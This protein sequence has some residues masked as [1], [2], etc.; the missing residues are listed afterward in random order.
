MVLRLLLDSLKLH[1]GK[2]SVFIP[3]VGSREA[4][5]DCLIN[6][7][8]L[9]TFYTIYTDWLGRAVNLRGRPL[10]FQLIFV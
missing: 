3:V 2:W 4:G 9:L 6:T 1:S 10:S 8:V 7:L 5:S